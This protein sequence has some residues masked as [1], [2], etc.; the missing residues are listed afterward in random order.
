MRFGVL[1]DADRSSGSSSTSGSS[2][3][4]AIGVAAD[5]SEEECARRSLTHRPAM[6]NFFRRNVGE[7]A[8]SGTRDE[9]ARKTIT[10]TFVPF[11][12]R[13]SSFIT[14]S[15][16]GH[17]RVHS[18]PQKRRLSSRAAGPVRQSASISSDRGTELSPSCG[19][20]SHHEVGDC[21]ARRRSIAPLPEIIPLIRHT[22]CR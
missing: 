7:L 14:T 9:R 4:V 21:R 5:G 2:R 18:G 6:K 3:G 15:A 22:T 8:A 11:N 10:H 12:N 20:W 19:D 16:P 17:L 1:I 13:G